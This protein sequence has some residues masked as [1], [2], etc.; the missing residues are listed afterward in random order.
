MVVFSDLAVVPACVYIVETILCRT[1]GKA[2]STPI[3]MK[4]RNYLVNTVFWKSEVPKKSIHHTVLSMDL[5]G[6]KYGVNGVH[7]S[8]IL[9]TNIYCKN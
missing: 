8:K 7:Q 3:I 2:V 5:C 4:H 9:S 6:V 1:G